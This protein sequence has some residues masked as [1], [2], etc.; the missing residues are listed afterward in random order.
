MKRSDFSLCTQSLS[1]KIVYGL[2]VLL[3]GS[4]I[5]TAQERCGSLGELSNALRL[6]Q[7]LYP[8]WKDRD[9]KVV[10]GHGSTTGLSRVNPA[11]IDAGSNFDIRVAA[12][13][14][15]PASG[16]GKAVNEPTTSGLIAGAEGP[17]DFHFDFQ[18]W[19]DFSLCRPRLLE[20]GMPTPNGASERQAVDLSLDA[21]MDLLNS[22]PEWTER[23]AL[24]EAREMGLKFAA[25]DEKALLK[26]IPLRQLA[27]L[28]SPL[29]ISK[30]SFELL[31]SRQERENG[32]ANAVLQWNIVLRE[33]GTTRFLN[34]TVEP[35]H[36]KITHLSEFDPEWTK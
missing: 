34:L 28:Y 10:L 31:K 6:I 36:G 23:R 33:I 11:P 30:M 27:A 4:S 2:A 1:R 26:V 9:L 29:R 18:L 15:S 5:A 13:P 24:V 20:V 22:H 8:E 12:P 17:V 19:K 21:T 3:S 35:F 25:G 16:S 7:A 14:P 32:G